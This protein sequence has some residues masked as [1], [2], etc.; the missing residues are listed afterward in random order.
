MSTYYWLMPRS[1]ECFI[2]LKRNPRC[3]LGMSHVYPVA[4]ICDYLKGGRGRDRT[5]TWAGTCRP[6]A[7]RKTGKQEES[8]PRAGRKTAS[9]RMRLPGSE[10]ILALLLLQTDSSSPT[11]LRPHTVIHAQWYAIQLLLQRQRGWLSMSSRTA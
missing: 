4:W 9:L 3:L 6:R 11:A 8:R 7:G 5:A 1:W 10:H 2:C